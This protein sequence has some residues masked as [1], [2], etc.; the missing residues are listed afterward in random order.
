MIFNKIHKTTHTQKKRRNPSFFCARD[1]TI[2]I[3]ST[4]L[5]F[6]VIVDVA[7]TIRIKNNIEIHQ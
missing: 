2:V 5:Q 7:K 4:H 6:A 1:R 3:I